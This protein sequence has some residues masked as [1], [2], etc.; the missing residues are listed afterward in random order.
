MKDRDK[1]DGAPKRAPS[2]D[3]SM[4]RITGSARTVCDGEEIFFE[5]PEMGRGS[6]EGSAR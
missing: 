3:W 1:S 2:L 6:V 4:V 5:I